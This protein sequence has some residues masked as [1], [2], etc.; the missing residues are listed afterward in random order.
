MKQLV[1]LYKAFRG[2]EWLYASL[3]SL[4]GS[5]DGA[6][7]VVAERSWQSENRQRENCSRV[8]EQ[9]GKD[10]PQFDLRVI[11]DSLPGTQ[12]EQYEVG[13]RKVAAAWDEPAVLLVDTDEV[14]TPGAI[15]RVKHALSDNPD[16]E[17]IQAAH[18][19][20]V[21]EPHFRV[22]PV[23]RNVPVVALK[24]PTFTARQF[25]HNAR[26]MNIGMTNYIFTDPLFHHFGYVRKQHSEVKTKMAVTSTQER[27]PYHENWYDEV[28]KKLPKGEDIYP[29]VNCE[30]TWKRLEV[31]NYPERA[32]PRV[33]TREKWV[34]ARIRKE[35][36]SRGYNYPRET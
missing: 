3:S 15:R 28:Y 26:F 14:W 35:F 29:Q 24:R 23:E 25:P 2:G 20:Y 5:V 19:S 9:F 13:M 21:K 12:A 17:C 31:L 33:A 4:L 22:W 18:W 30:A 36:R 6:V 10:N 32:L 34:D 8:A 16:A 1:A 11:Y 27:I 7:V